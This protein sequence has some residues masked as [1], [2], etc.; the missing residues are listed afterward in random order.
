[1][2]SL[3]PCD[4]TRLTR[5][6]MFLSLL[7]IWTSL[8]ERSK[9]ALAREV[10]RRTEK[11]D[12]RSFFLFPLSCY[13]SCSLRRSRFSREKEDD[14]SGKWIHCLTKAREQKNPVIRSLRP[15][16]K[17]VNSPFFLIQWNPVNTVTNG[18]KK[19]GRINEGFFL[20]DRITEVTVR[21]DST[22]FQNNFLVF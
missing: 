3:L 21:R 22:V 14:N 12:G 18:P 6:Q 20:C 9:G 15:H 7:F 8:K 2:F 17:M 11:K 4:E 16:S 5:P 19:F 13:S 1:M 10:M